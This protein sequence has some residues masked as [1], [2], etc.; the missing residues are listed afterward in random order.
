MKTYNQNGT[1]SESEYVFA[2]NDFFAIQQYI[3]NGRSRF[4]TREIN[5]FKN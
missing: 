5:L 4:F 2:D 3:N 1:I